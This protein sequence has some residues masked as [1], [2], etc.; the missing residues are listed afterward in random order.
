[1]SPD[2]HRVRYFVVRELPVA[3][4][5]L[6]PEYISESLRISQKRTV[7]ILEELEDGLTFLVRNRSGAVSWAFP[8]TVEP[9]PHRIRF[10]S[11]E[12]IYAA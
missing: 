7:Q 10:N 2:H 6:D 5:A 8:V 1:M 4:H 11:G 12:Q 9:T 3:G